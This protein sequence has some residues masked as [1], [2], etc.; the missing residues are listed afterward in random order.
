[1]LHT[2]KCVTHPKVCYTV[3]YTVCFFAVHGWL[4]RVHCHGEMRALPLSIHARQAGRWSHVL[5]WRLQLALRRGAEHR[6]TASG[7][8]GIGGARGRPRC[9]PPATHA[10]HGGEPAILNAGFFVIERSGALVSSC[11]QTLDHRVLECSGVSS[12]VLSAECSV[13]QCLVLSMIECLSARA[14]E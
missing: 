9:A 4:C 7:L 1:M 14:V 3:C 8:G 10:R 12:S 11:P 2:K 6:P 13:D 5:G